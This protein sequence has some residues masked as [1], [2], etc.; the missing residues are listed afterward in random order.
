MTRSQDA[1]VAV[2]FW[3]RNDTSVPH[4][5]KHG[6]YAIEVD[7]TWGEPE[8]FFPTTSCDFDS[9]FNAHQIIFDLT[10]CVS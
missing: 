4:A 3:A 2:Y 6:E 9:H 5:V 1:G 8:A 7:D 10:L